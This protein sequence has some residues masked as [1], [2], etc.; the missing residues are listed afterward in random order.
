[1][2]RMARWLGATCAA[3]VGFWANGARASDGGELLEGRSRH[4]ES[5]QHFALEFRFSPYRP[6]IDSEPGLNGNTPYKDVY[7]TM[8]RLV[9][10]IEFDWQF[11]RIPYF[12]TLGAGAAVGYTDISANAKIRGTN[13]PQDSAQDT[14]LTLYPMYAVGVVR[15]DALWKYAHV[16]IVPYAKLGLG[17]ALWRASGPTGTSVSQNVSAKG[18]STGMHYALGASL[19]L[20]F[21]DYSSSRYMDVDYGINQTHVFFEYYMSELDGFGDNN[22]L[23][24]GSRTWATG[25]AF[26]F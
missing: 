8:P 7:G 21:L 19:A 17:Y 24:V 16:P 3:L 1:M 12:G 23:R 26:E 13:P 6:R 11:F 15:A 4:F 2:K 10:Q 9:L 22:T 18:H 14:S 20:N 25:L 5:P